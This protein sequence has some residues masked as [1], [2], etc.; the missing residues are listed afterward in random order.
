MPWLRVSHAA[1]VTPGRLGALVA[2]VRPDRGR[3]CDDDA[4]EPERLDKYWHWQQL[5][6][7]NKGDDPSAVAIHWETRRRSKAADMM[8]KYAVE[9][10]HSHRT[11]DVV[12]DPHTPKQT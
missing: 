1:F 10:V 12:A 8:G 3:D 9:V 11:P 5:L 4:E 2:P 7:R 6:V